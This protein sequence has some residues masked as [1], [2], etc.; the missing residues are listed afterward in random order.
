MNGTIKLLLQELCL[1][2]NVLV[3]FGIPILGLLFLNKRY[4][5]EVR[6]FITGILA[7]VISQPLLRIPLLYYVFPNFSWFL[8]LQHNPYSYGLF[9]GLTAGIFEETARLIF[10]K[11]LLKNRTRISDGFAFGFGHGG[12]EAMIFTGI[13][14]IAAMLL[15][16]TNP[17]GLSGVGC[18]SILTG[19]F[20]RIAAMTFHIGASLL[21][22]YG[23]R[24]HKAIQ[25]T[26]LAIILHG[27]MDSMITILPASIGLGTAGLE[28]Y[29]MIVGLLVLGLSIVLFR[30]NEIHREI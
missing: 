12:I 24:E 23:I 26:V 17:A 28:A 19:G 21:V 14:C 7:F 8:I 29:A 22:L 20:E 16:L 1:L 4:K 18:L 6:P 11:L 3:C 9:L 27:L 25:Y 2:V 30:R 10:M 5:K 15:P 13:N